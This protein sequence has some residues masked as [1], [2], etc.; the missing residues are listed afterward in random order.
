MLAPILGIG[1]ALL[2]V[3]LPNFIAESLT[4]IGHSAGGVAAGSTLIASSLLSAVTL[5]IGLALLGGKLRGGGRAKTL[6]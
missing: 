2:A 3:P 6:R 4:L 1:F 5:A